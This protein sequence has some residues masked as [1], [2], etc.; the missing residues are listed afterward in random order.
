MVQLVQW[1]ED[2]SNKLLSTA[3]FSSHATCDTCGYAWRRLGMPR[4]LFSINYAQWQTARPLQWLLSVRRSSG[5]YGLGAGKKGWQ[6]DWVNGAGVIPI[7]VGAWDRGAYVD[8]STGGGDILPLLWGFYSASALIAMQTAVLARAILSVRPSVRP[9][10]RHIPVS[11]QTND[12]DRAIFSIRQDNHSS[13]W[14]GKVCPDI[15]WESH[16]ASALKRSTLLSL[17]KIWHIISHNLETAQD[18]R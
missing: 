6:C 11:F 15:R 3:P 2:D 12:Y 8:V 5:C 4:Q 14:R 10:V 17:S 1:S 7:V 13:F 18:R 16:P 9:S